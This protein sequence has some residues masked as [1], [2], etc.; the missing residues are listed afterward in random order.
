M[1]VLWSST[2]YL[3]FILVCTAGLATG[4]ITVPGYLMLLCTVQLVGNVCHL[5]K[6][7]FNRSVLLV[8][9][10][11]FCQVL[12]VIW[13]SSSCAVSYLSLLPYTAGLSRCCYDLNGLS[14]AHYPL[15]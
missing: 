14:L 13:T 4:A 10:Q 1:V 6:V 5:S 8:S 9:Y 11:S 2:V 12:Y 15:L 3:H 7:N